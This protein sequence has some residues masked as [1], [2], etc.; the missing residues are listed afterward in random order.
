MSERD[1]AEMLNIRAFMI[2]RILTQR[3]INPVV[4]CSHL[5]PVRIALPRLDAT[6]VCSLRTLLYGGKGSAA[7]NFI[8]CKS[9]DV[10]VNALFEYTR[11]YDS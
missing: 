7:R 2:T 6:A 8:I 4:L 1:V 3:H 10:G 9:S 5:V 11:N